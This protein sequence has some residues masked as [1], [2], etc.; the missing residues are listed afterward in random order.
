MSLWSEIDIVIVFMVAFCWHLSVFIVYAL[1]GDAVVS[2]YFLS[3]RHSWNLLLDRPARGAPLTSVSPRLC[4]TCTCSSGFLCGDLIKHKF[5]SG[6]WQ[7]KKCLKTG[8]WQGLRVGAYQ[9]GAGAFGAPAVLGPQPDW[10]WCLG[11][12]VLVCRTWYSGPRAGFY[13]QP[14]SK[15]VWHTE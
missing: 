4:E 12:V 14:S 2:H 8:I 11:Q 3:L 5:I 7:N 15:V 1:G 9:D 10:S 13:F 6:I